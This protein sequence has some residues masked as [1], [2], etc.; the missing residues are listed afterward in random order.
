MKDRN[1]TPRLAIAGL[2]SGLVTPISQFLLVKILD[3]GYVGSRPLFYAAS[4]L[5]A[6]LVTLVYGTSLARL[7]AAATGCLVGTA[8]F[9]KVAVQSGWATELGN[10]FDWVLVLGF[11]CVAIAGVAG[12]R[13]LIRRRHTINAPETGAENS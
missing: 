7:T 12:A 2:T 1:A 6:F 5:P 9:Y 4:C 3:A 13:S 10:D 11:N 8:A